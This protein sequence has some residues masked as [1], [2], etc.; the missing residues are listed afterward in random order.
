MSILRIPK[1]LLE[2][3]KDEIIKT[4]DK[5]QSQKELNNVT[6]RKVRK[7]NKAE[8][9]KEKGKWITVIYP[10]KIPPY[11]RVFLKDNFPEIPDAEELAEKVKKEAETP[12]ITNNPLSMKNVKKTTNPDLPKLSSI[13][14]LSDPITKR[15]I[16]KEFKNSSKKVAKSKDINPKAIGQSKQDIGKVKSKKATISTDKPKTAADTLANKKVQEVDSTLVKIRDLYAN[17]KIK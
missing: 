4:I 15:T 13:K 5:D 12:K 14:V 6:N 11:R 1:I 10:N 17:R 3:K 9:E 16:S 8:Q 7:S 2:P